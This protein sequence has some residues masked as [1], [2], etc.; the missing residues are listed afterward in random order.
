ML[1][2]SDRLHV[3]MPLLSW[4]TGCTLGD[5]DDHPVEMWVPS[6]GEALCGPEKQR[7]LYNQH[8]LHAEAAEVFS[9]NGFH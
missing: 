6:H 8:A 3:P 9:K 5:L 2:Q 1:A 7:R 4:M